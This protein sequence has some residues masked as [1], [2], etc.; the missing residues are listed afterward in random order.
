MATHAFFAVCILMA[1]SVMAEPTATMPAAIVFAPKGNAQAAIT[2]F[3]S[4]GATGL[5]QGTTVT[6][7][8]DDHGLKVTF[9]CAD[10]RVEG[11]SRTHDDD[12]MWR[13]DAVEIFLDPGHTHDFSS[14]WIHILVS[15]AGCV[16]D[17]RGPG[18]VYSGG[19]RYARDRSYIARA[20]QS[21]VIRTAD[22]WRAEM[23]IPWENLGAHP[24]IGDVWGLN[25]IRGDQPQTNYHYWVPVT[26][27]LQIEQWGHIVFA[28]EQGRADGAVRKITEMHATMFGKIK[29]LK[30]CVERITRGEGFMPWQSREAVSED[31]TAFRVQVEQ[32]KDRM[33]AGRMPVRHPALFTKEQWACGRRNISETAWGKAWFNTLKEKADYIVSQPDN[34]VERMIPMLTPTS[35]YGFTCPNCVGKFSQ[36]GAGYQIIAWDYRNPEVIHCMVCGQSYPDPRFP[37]SGAISLPRRGQVISYYRNTAE[38]AHPDDRS[39]TYAWKWVGKPIHISFEGIIRFKKITFM[40]E[41]TRYLGLAYR[42]TGD[43]RYARRAADILKRLT[44]CVPNWAYHDYWDTYA[45]CDPLYAAWHSKGLRLEWKRNPNGSAYKEI[46][47]PIVT[48]NGVYFAGMLESYWGAGRVNACDAILM[49]NICLAYDVI[50]DAEDAAG[51]EFLSPDWRTKIERDLILEYIIGGEPFLGGAGKTDNVSNK[52]PYVY[53][54]MAMAGRCLGLP[55]FVDVSLRGYKALLDKSFLGDGFSHE[56][57][58]Y[59]LM[60]LTGII[61]VPETL[62]GFRWPRGF[63]GRSET[64]D[65]YR[66]DPQ[67]RLIM[68]AALDQLRPNGKYLPL[69]DTL[70]TKAPSPSL[71]ELGLAR[72]PELFSGSLPSIYRAQKDETKTAAIPYSLSQPGEYAVFNLTDKALSVDRLQLPEIYFP[73]WQTAILRHGHGPNATVLAMP[74]NPP[75]NHRH[76]DNLAL[77]YSDNGRTIL[78]EMGYV[79]DTVMRGWGGSTLSHNLVVVDD[80]NQL[81]NGFPSRSSRLCMMAT[82]PRVSVVEGESKAYSQCNEYRR[83]VALIKGPGAQSF[84]IDIFRVRG[85]EKHA[86]R[87]FSEIASSDSPGGALVF[88]GVIM[89]EEKPLPDY[90]GSVKSEHIYGLRD[91]R[92]VD[93]PPASWTATWSETGRTYRL[94]ML[95]KAD[96]VEASHGPGQET[97]WQVGRRVRYLDVIN[98]GNEVKSCFI[99]VH[100][101]GSPDGTMPI[102]KA[103]RLPVPES[104]GPEAVAIRIE[105]SWGTYLFFNEIATEVE[106]DGIR[107]QGKF[108]VICKPTSGRHWL[109]SVGAATV[110]SGS[111]GIT[112]APAIWTGPISSSTENSI[113]TEG[114]RPTG[115][116]V[117][118]EGVLQYILIGSTG[119]PVKKVG[120]HRIL[121]DRFPIPPAKDFMLHAVQYLEE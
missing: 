76:R 13:D 79:G 7:G 45:D 14:K 74:F 59:T 108:G 20:M 36:E 87:L 60:F 23:A 44:V 95:S 10:S 27:F 12:N 90:S 66:D 19:G 56:S 105:T 25:L 89:P 47:K 49:E 106:V 26:S 119:Y 112:N 73:D 114:P 64:V 61:K 71:Y 28:D 16:Y 22:G 42:L 84:A 91:T 9:D 99:A 53:S 51:K 65:S 75:G 70:V 41:A 86:Y 15:A 101:P 107:C 120:K 68:R 96:A 57:P 94:H 3:V 80:Q 46:E 24:A 55:E 88:D 109:F 77:F 117:F 62:R 39:G 82:S 100:E 72:Y 63:P 121:I 35:H 38:Q 93:M 31:E 43:P 40:M 78:G 104:A 52:S 30:E 48:N 2:N 83:L 92:R 11:Q 111:F 32:R 18:D 6:L 69:S 37:E 98:E 85:G 113:D 1:H 58:S 115:W 116:P 5:L 67:L 4:L 50:C 118:G 103:I 110:K 17:E 21:R 97:T 29:F 34:Y 54:P 81:F 33:L 102:V 8:W